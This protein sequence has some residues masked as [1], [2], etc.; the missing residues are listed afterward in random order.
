MH[1]EARAQPQVCFESTVF[2]CVFM[3]VCVYVRTFM[4][5]LGT[6][7][8]NTSICCVSLKTITKEPLPSGFF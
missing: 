4:W 6:Q 8:L 3:G 2:V 5:V 1:V 7:I